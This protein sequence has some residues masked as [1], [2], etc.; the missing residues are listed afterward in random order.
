MN[1]NHISSD[2]QLSEN[3]LGSLATS[4]I[5]VAAK[6]HQHLQQIQGV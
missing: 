1:K 2:S 3:W 4:A 5:H 6:K